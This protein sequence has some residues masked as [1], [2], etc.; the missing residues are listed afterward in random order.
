MAA[1]RAAPAASLHRL[2][3]HSL[4][5]RRRRPPP[6]PPQEFGGA[7]ADATRALELDPRYAKAYY[8]R[9]DA[10]FALGHFKDAVRDFRAAIRLAPSDPDLRRKV[11]N[12]GLAAGCK[13]AVA[14][15]A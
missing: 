13:R 5:H 15:V 14:A 7:I 11:R 10:S 8:R 12:G 6:T 2:W 3:A 4:A 9:G 1:P